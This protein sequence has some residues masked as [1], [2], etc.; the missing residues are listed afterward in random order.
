MIVLASFVFSASLQANPTNRSNSGGDEKMGGSVRTESSIQYLRSRYGE[1]PS[2]WPCDQRVDLGVPVDQI[3]AGEPP[4]DSNG[5]RG[6]R[7]M[8][9]R[10]N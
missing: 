6:M 10:A 1:D 9:D 2:R 4:A 5:V 8:R 3:R 7:R